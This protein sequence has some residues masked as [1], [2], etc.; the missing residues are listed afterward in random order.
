MGKIAE[1]RRVGFFDCARALCMLYIVCVWHLYRNIQWNINLDTPLFNSITRGALAAFFFISAYFLGKRPVRSFRDALG[2]YKKRLL[3]FYPLYFIA[4]T[5]LL[6]VFLITGV[7][8]IESVRQYV[9]TLFG[10]STIFTPA[11]A[12][13]WFISM[14]ILFYLI[15]PLVNALGKAWQK[16]ACIAVL[17]AL[18]L[19]LRQAGFEAD[20]RLLLYLPVYGLGLILAKTEIPQKPC[21]PALLV[22]LAAFIAGVLLSARFDAFAMQYLV[23]LPF[24]PLVIEAGKIIACCGPLERIFKFIS[25]GSMV[26]YLFHRQFFGVLLSILGKFPVWF[27]YLLVVPA[28]LAVSWLVQRIYD[29]IMNRIIQ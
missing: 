29:R 11:P 12:T 13:V 3:R 8:Y 20:A 16:A 28:L 27:A 25:Y 7:E 24:I 17:F 9:L 19:I 10:L 6:A 4:C 18:L 15:T 26:A 23:M 22:S 21:L 2:F 5:S 14:L 1:S